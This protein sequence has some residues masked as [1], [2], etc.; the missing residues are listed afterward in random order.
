[1]VLHTLPHRVCESTCYINGL[2]DLLAWKG[3]DYTDFLLFGDRWKYRNKRFYNRLKLLQ[4][5]EKVH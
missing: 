1:M 3:A 5:P 2:E 4:Q